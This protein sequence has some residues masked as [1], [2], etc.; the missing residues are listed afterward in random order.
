MLK[1]TITIE[2][3]EPEHLVA[4]VEDVAQCVRSDFTIGNYEGKEYKYK[5]HVTI[6]D[7]SH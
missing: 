1:L 2:A 5:Y 7:T 6:D 3:S 4:G